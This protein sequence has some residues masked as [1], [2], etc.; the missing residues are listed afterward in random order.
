MDFNR[1]YENTALE[2]KLV[3]LT[4]PINSRLTSGVVVFSLK[5]EFGLNNILI[6]MY[7]Y[8]HARARANV[9]FKK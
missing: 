2:Q 5:L 3:V 6:H 1:S 8:M 7:A 9:N 4:N